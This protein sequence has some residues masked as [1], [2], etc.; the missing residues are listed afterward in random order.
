MP[1]D[2]V[3]DPT[4]KLSDKT[5]TVGHLRD[6]LRKYPDTTPVVLF[7]AGYVYPVMDINQARPEEINLPQTVVE[8]SGGLIPLQE[9]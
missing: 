3:L 2:D 7:A 4:T 1:T 9:Y 8:L 5:L 6:E